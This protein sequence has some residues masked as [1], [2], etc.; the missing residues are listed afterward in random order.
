MSSSNILADQSS[1][2]FVAELRP[3]LRVV[4]VSPMS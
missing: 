1:I 4:A 2:A 3:Q